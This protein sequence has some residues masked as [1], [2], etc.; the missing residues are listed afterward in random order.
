MIEG[1]LK[2]DGQNRWRFF[3]DNGQCLKFAPKQVVQVKI[4]DDWIFT[5]VEDYRDNVYPLVKGLRFYEGQR[6]RVK[7]VELEGFCE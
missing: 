3:L 4:G 6:C 5:P 7:Y 2:S 1:I